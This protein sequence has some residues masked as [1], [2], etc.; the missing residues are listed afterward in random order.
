MSKMGYIYAFCLL[1]CIVCLSQAAPARSG[2]WDEFALETKYMKSSLE[3]DDDLPLGWES[4]S[5]GMTLEN[6]TLQPSSLLLAVAE[7]NLKDQPEAYAF[8]PPSHSNMIDDTVTPSSNP[9]TEISGKRQRLENDTANRIGSNLE[10]VM[11]ALLNS[12]SSLS[13]KI[14]LIEEKLQ[15]MEVRI[16]E[17]TLYFR[18][19]L[20]SSVL[21]TGLFHVLFHVG[22]LQARYDSSSFGEREKRA[23]KLERNSS[24]FMAFRGKTL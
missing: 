16:D 7:V 10:T 12:V 3:S 5:N 17:V 20:S 22:V 24:F 11:T 2:C 13:N 21:L 6:M 15:V 19:Y 8:L 18:H 23:S 1:K 14:G 9:S 4:R